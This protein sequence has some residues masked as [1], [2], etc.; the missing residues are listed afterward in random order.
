MVGEGTRQKEPSEGT[1]RGREH[2]LTPFW[3][4]PY[5]ALTLTSF[6]ILP[7]CIKGILEGNIYHPLTPLESG[8]CPHQSF[9]G[10]I[11]SLLTSAQACWSHY[12]VLLLQVIR[13]LVGKR[14]C[15]GW[16]FT[17]LQVTEYSAEQCLHC[18]NISYF[19][20]KSRGRL[21]RVC[22]AVQQYSRTQALSSIFNILMFCSHASLLLVTR[23]LQLLQ[24]SSS[25]TVFKTRKQQGRKLA[26]KECS[27]HQ[28]E[29]HLHSPELRHGYWSQLYFLLWPLNMTISL[30]PSDKLKRS[31]VST[32]LLCT[33]ITE[34]N[35]FLSLLK[36][37]SSSMNLTFLPQY[38]IHIY[39]I[40]FSMKE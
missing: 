12:A 21:F 2:S 26:E 20:N 13:G 22:L 6:Y 18:R 1:P 31:S 10:V 7:Q 25:H 30:T 14:H 9:T 37:P 4:H 8:L 16:E 23:W 40:Y 35:A 11:S 15:I 32:H 24:V 33:L 34:L 5:L 36:C 28:E 17:S 3:L 29:K 19:L 27:F 38:L 39:P